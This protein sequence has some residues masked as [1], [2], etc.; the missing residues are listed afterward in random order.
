M[1]ITVAAATVREL[2]EVERV[3]L[4][5]LPYSAPSAQTF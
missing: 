5:A 1:R 2:I 3:V 4:N